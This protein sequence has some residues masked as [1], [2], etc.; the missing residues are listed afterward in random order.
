[1]EKMFIGLIIIS[2][3]AIIGYL[4]FDLGQF[5]NNKRLK[6]DVYLEQ[7]MAEHIGTL[8]YVYGYPLVDTYQQQYNETHRLSDDQIVYAPV[9][10]FYYYPDIVTPET[11]GNLR[12]PNA[13]TLYFSGWY[14]ISKEPLIIHTPDTQ[15]RYYTIAVTDAYSEVTHIGRRTTGTAQQ[16]FAIITP[17]W[18]GKLPNGVKKI[19]SASNRGWLLGR[20]MVNGKDDFTEAKT[21]M[22]NIWLAS[23][24]E[25]KKG[26]RPELPAEI[27]AEKI[28]IADDLKFFSIVNQSLKQLPP[29]EGEAALMAQ[30]DAIGIGPNS[31]FDEKDLSESRRKGLEKALKNG[32]AIIEASTQRTI[33][34]QNGWMILYDAGRYGF[35]YLSRASVTRG[36]YANLPEESIYPAR[37]YDSSDNILHGKN[38]YTLHF[39]KN[40]LPPANGFWSFSAYK[41][42]KNLTLEKNALE[43]YSLG[44]YN[45]QLKYN[46][47]GSLTLV[48]QHKKPK[49][50]SNWLP[51][52]KGNFLLVMRL[53]EPKENILKRQYSLPN[54][55]IKKY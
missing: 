21:M 30:F 23:L 50:T 31:D 10:R 46:S 54:L 17:D 55:I 41:L 29:R 5:I 38:T 28:A 24:S 47:D 15:G 7:H 19:V 53:Y 11:A 39:E 14:D 34:D 22:N 3:I 6:N 52:P 12:A 26:Q 9:N 8:A 36:G 13:D 37:I 49:E 4:T 44:S 33:P 25:F 43:R 35:D 18:D 32:R 45:K 20:M 2:L 40:K 16:Y 48:F 27:K 51:T 42:N 1:M